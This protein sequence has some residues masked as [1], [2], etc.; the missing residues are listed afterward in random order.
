MADEAASDPTPPCTQTHNL[1]VRMQ[2]KSFSRNTLKF[3]HLVISL[4]HREW[5][6]DF[7]TYA[8]AAG[9]R[10]MIETV[11]SGGHDVGLEID[12]HIEEVDLNTD[13]FEESLAAGS[14]WTR[15]VHLDHAKLRVRTSWDHAQFSSAT[16]LPVDQPLMREESALP[17]EPIKRV[18]LVEEA[19]KALPLAPRRSSSTTRNTQTRLPIRVVVQQGVQASQ[20]ARARE[21]DVCARTNY[22]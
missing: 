9:F 21:L 5:A 14:P 22:S 10:C 2:F 3:R 1:R 19:Q 17:R 6:Q 7:A 12:T 15:V 13:P 16:R 8:E 11:Y 4:P 18:L 20:A